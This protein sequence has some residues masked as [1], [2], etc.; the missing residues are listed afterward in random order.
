MN[1]LSL[2]AERSS[3]NIISPSINSQKQSLFTIFQK[4]SNEEK[5]DCFNNL[6]DSQ[7]LNEAFK[8][9]ENQKLKFGPNISFYNSLDNYVHKERQSEPNI[10]NVNDFDLNLPK[11][12]DHTDINASKLSVCEKRLSASQ[13]NVFRRSFQNNKSKTL[14]KKNI[15]KK[16][17]FYNVIS[18]FYIAKTFISKLKNLS[19]Y[20]LPDKLKSKHFNM[21]NDWAYYKYTFSKKNVSFFSIKWFF[22]KFF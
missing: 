22:K 2:E 15:D 7:K 6:T 11:A 16:K 8:R 21:I 12:I 4:N 14:K 20:R 9:I 5:K 1:K 13:E 19:K 3:I 18:D 17:T 10:L